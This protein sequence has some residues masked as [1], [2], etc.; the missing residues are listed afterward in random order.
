M[1][2]HQAQLRHLDTSHYDARNASKALWGC[3][4]E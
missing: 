3:Q 2:V 4:V 1:L